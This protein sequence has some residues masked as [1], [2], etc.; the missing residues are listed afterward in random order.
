MKRSYRSGER[1]RYR[2]GVK[3]ERAKL[4][5]ANGHPFAARTFIKKN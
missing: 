5:A 3:V 4:E 2:I 1:S